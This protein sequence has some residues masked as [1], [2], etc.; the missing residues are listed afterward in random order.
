MKIWR[1]EVD[2]QDYESFKLVNEDRQFLKDFKA[3]AFSATVFKNDFIGEP[4]EL[5]EG[6]EKT[7]YPK[8]WSA[9]GIPLINKKSAESLIKIISGD[10]ELVS[11]DYVDGDYYI[12][13]ILSVLDAVDNDKSVFRKLDTGLVVGLER[14]ELKSQIIDGHNIF[15]LYLNG[16]I[17]TTEVFVSDIFK[18]AVEEV[19]LKGFKFVEVWGE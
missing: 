17:M 3:K 7:D 6:E 15:K 10:A 8:F 1:L 16:R 14:Y 9:S 4:I 19:Q 5:V 13:N 12:V 2:F 18:K 11:V